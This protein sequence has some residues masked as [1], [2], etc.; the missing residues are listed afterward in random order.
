MKH[1]PN[2]TA[3]NALFDEY[4]T[5][6]GAEM[7]DFLQLY[8]TSLERDAELGAVQGKPEHVEQAEEDILETLRD[9]RRQVEQLKE[10]FADQTA[11]SGDRAA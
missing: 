7:G 4:R 6:V 2:N 3:T 9:A 5:L 11:L 8:L 10:R 1:T